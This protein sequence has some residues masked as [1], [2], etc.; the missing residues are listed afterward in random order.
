MKAIYRVVP[1]R[2]GWGID[3]GND[4]V[5]PYATKEAAFEAAAMAATNAIKLGHEVNL[6]VPG[7]EAGESALGA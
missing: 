4:I 3:E 7:R 6:T 1:F 2:E 5:G